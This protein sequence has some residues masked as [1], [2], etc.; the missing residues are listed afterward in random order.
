MVHVNGLS[1]NVGGALTSLHFNLRGE[2]FSY[3]LDK[4]VGWTV[5]SK[6][7]E[8]MVK[9]FAKKDKERAW[10][11]GRKAAKRAKLIDEQ[12]Q[13]CT[14]SVKRLRLEKEGE[15][16]ELTYTPCSSINKKN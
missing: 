8:R 16:N 5:N 15:N 9:K 2:M 14:T 11:I 13:N 3:L 6:F 1:V 10:R 4:A 7:T 12:A